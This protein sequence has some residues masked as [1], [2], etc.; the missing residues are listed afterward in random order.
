MHV[1]LLPALDRFIVIRSKR[2]SG[3]F[4]GNHFRLIESERIEGCVD[5]PRSD[6]AQVATHLMREI[7]AV[8]AFGP[9]NQKTIRMEG[10]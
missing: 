10:V 3:E 2:T 4:Q 5:L 7:A 6:R 9:K 1:A 8:D